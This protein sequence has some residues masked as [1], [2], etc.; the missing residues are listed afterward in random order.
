G[1]RGSDDPQ[2]GNWSLR[3][4]GS[5]SEPGP[6]QP[7]AFRGVCRVPGPPPT[8]RDVMSPSVDRARPGAPRLGVAAALIAA[9]L[10]AMFVAVAPTSHATEVSD[11]ECGVPGVAAVYEYRYRVRTKLYGEKEI[12]SIKGWTF[13]EGGNTS[14]RVN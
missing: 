7:R 3:P 10:A 8:G 13:Q 5:Y 9:L 12:K 6:E 14:V 2:A 4:A 11:D 1:R